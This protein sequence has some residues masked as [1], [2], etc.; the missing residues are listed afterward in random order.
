MIA[1]ATNLSF[2]QWR[3]TAVAACLGMAAIVHTHPAAAQS[4]P[5]EVPTGSPTEHLQL[6]PYLI[7]NGYTGGGGLGDTRVVSTTCEDGNPVLARKFDV[8]GSGEVIVGLVV[9]VGS[10]FIPGIGGAAAGFGYGL[11]TK[12]GTVVVNPVAG[13]CVPLDAGAAPVAVMQS[14]RPVLASAAA[15][16][17]LDGP[18]DSMP[19]AQPPPY[20]AAPSNYRAAA[21][22]VAAAPAASFA[23]PQYTSA[24][25]YPAASGSS[26]APSSFRLD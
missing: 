23:A 10:N 9:G 5:A 22:Q 16:F 18:G 11:V 21:A 3:N 24:P 4:A 20:A 2:R 26:A 19:L 17:R 8:E 14:Q 1:S 7:A 12:T 6:G 15:S 13:A 25:S